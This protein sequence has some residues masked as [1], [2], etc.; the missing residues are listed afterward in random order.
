MDA[1]QSD[2]VEYKGKGARLATTEDSELCEGATLTTS[3]MRLN[4]YSHH[5]LRRFYFAWRC[6]HENCVQKRDR[7]GGQD[8]GVRG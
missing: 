3:Y 8:Y 1:Q 6:K 4:G 7:I 2:I 5:S